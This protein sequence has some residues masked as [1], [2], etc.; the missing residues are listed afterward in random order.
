MTNW[1]GFM[2]LSVEFLIV[3]SEIHVD[4]RHLPGDLAIWFIILLELTTFVLLF[5]AYAIM[6][7]KDPE[8]FNTAQLMLDRS[9]GLLNTLL[10]IGGSWCVV[11]GVHAMRDGIR[12]VGLRWLIAAQ[13]CGLAFLILKSREY[14]DLFALGIDMDT[15]R[16]FTF[17]FTL[18]GFHFLHVLAAIIILAILTIHNRAGTCD[19]DRLHGLETG[20]AFWHMVDLLWIVLFPLIY[21]MR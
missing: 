19:P 7:S 8:L 9:K 17:Y 20:G 5:G 15:N 14:S 2:R 1:L 12:Q 21:L 13:A 4:E 6:R 11:H 10:L 16:F 18:T 3:E